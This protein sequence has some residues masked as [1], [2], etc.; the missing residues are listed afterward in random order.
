MCDAI[1]VLNAGSSSLKFSIFKVADEMLRLE[2]GGQIDGLGTTPHFKAKDAGKQVLVDVD[3]KSTTKT[4]G[5]AEGFLHL[6]KWMREQFGAKLSP[7]AVG[8]RMA[9]GGQD[10][11]EPTIIKN[12]VLAKLEQLI[13]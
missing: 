10:F 8:H 1:I 9:H 2:A 4:F 11:V 6:A 7:I 5:H 12:G 3:L 13:P